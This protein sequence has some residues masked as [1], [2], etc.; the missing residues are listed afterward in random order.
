MPEAARFDPIDP[1]DR[2]DAAYPID[3]TDRAIVDTLQGGFPIC[4]RPYAAAAEAL[5]ISEDALLARLQ[6]LLAARVLTRFG[7]LFQI[8]RC[9]GSFVLAA[10]DVPEGDW[11]RVV[12]LVNALP[13]VAH[14]YR[15]ESEHHAAPNMWFVLAAE[16][17]AAIERAISRLEQETGLPVLAFPKRAEYFVDLRLPVRA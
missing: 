17:N 13:E 11:Q 7:P 5:G 9:G 6:R 14:N 16:N 12:A 3:P 4:E 1:I 2:A 8:E 10:I 15:R